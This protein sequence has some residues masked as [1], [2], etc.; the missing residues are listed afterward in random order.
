MFSDKNINALQSSVKMQ[1]Q[2]Q[3]KSDME[4][5]RHQRTSTANS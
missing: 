3:Q 1:L 5:G 4:D 2:S